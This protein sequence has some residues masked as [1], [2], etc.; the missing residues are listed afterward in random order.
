MTSL[1]RTSDVVAE[2]SLRDS[3]TKDRFY[4]WPGCVAVGAPVC[5]GLVQTFT[6]RPSVWLVLPF[7]F[8]LIGLLM[9]LLAGLRSLVCSAVF[10]WR[11]KPRA[12]LSCAIFPL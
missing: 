10:A 8:F 9:F 5:F 2:A 1:R 4:L 12:A 7:P 6:P 11:A 3:G